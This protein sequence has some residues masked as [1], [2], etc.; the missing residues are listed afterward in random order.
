MKII[1]RI[2][3]SNDGDSSPSLPVESEIALRPTTEEGY[4]DLAARV[5][6]SLPSSKTDLPS[7][8]PKK[9]KV[10]LG[11]P[12]SPGGGGDLATLLPGGQTTDPN[13]TYTI[14]G[15]TRE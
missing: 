1:R 2:K 6:A 11:Q 14:N 5:R 10:I 4:D 3:R 7:N 8:L 15:P 13:W 9:G 12:G